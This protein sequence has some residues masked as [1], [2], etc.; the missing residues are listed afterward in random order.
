MATAGGRSRGQPSS[1]L[2]LVVANVSLSFTVFS[3]RGQGHAI[4]PGSGREFALERTAGD[5]ERPC[6]W[7]QAL[8]DGACRSAMG[9]L[10]RAADVSTEHLSNARPRVCRPRASGRYWSCLPGC[11]GDSTESFFAGR[12]FVSLSAGCDRNS[13]NVPCCTRENE[14]ELGSSMWCCRPVCDGRGSSGSNFRIAQRSPARRSW[15][16]RRAAA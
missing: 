1:E 3:R 4:Q 13:R 8:C 15:S 14:L 7:R 12:L 11:G 2:T 10:H 6:S 16:L 9:M 5:F